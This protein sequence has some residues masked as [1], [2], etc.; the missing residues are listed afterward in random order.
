MVDPR[1]TDIKSLFCSSCFAFKLSL[2]SLTLNPHG[3]PRMIT[4]R[5]LCARF[6]L[7]N[8]GRVSLYSTS[9]VP[10]RSGKPWNP[11]LNVLYR[12]I[13][14]I[15]DPRVSIVPILEQWIEEGRTVSRAPLL[16]IV[17]EL[18]RYKRY[19]H[20]LEVFLDVLLLFLS[21]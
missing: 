8:G 5:N 7:R 1:H 11:C 18:R 6:V 16:A 14:P 17:K 10:T 20:A 9:T 4:A 2:L 15:G 12:R 19:A 21:F 3:F 13:S